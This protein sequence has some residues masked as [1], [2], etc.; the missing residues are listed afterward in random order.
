[1]PSWERR[2]VL[3]LGKTYPNYSRKYD[4]VACTGG[5]VEPSLEMVRLFPVPFRYLDRTD[6]FTAWQYIEADITRDRSDPRPESYRVDPD[7]I[8]VQKTVPS[9]QHDLRVR[10]LRR[11]PHF[12]ESVEELFRRNEQKKTSL[13][14]VQPLEIINFAVEPRSEQEREEWLEKEAEI[15]AQERMFTQLKK[16]DFPEAKFFIKW[17]C[18][19]SACKTHRMSILQWGI[20]ELARK[21]TEREDPDGQTKLLDKMRE[22][23]DAKKKDI[24]LFL[25]NFRAKTYN[26]GLMDSYSAK[27]ERQTT[28]LA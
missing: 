15:L 3:I 28:F 20:H 26:F 21:L 19:D 4:E 9:A 12:C 22:Q 13:G 6:Q 8:E 16:L 10:M 14:I 17:R 2:R 24:Y 7:S 1:M 23:L 18:K 25:G 5:L 27:K 11:S